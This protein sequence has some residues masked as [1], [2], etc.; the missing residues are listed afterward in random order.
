[1]NCIV[2]G[3]A[4]SD[5]T[6]QLSL[7]LSYDGEGAGSS[8]GRQA[9]NIPHAF[10]TKKGGNVKQKQYYNKFNEDFKMVHIKKKK[11]TQRKKAIRDL[12]T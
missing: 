9:N 7:S 3:V 5:T 2:H 10:R 8:P 4:E 12:R 11:N 1:M 6:E